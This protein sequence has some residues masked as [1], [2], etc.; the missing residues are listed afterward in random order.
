MSIKLRD[1]LIQEIG[2]FIT[3]REVR[4]IEIRISARLTLYNI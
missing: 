1:V 2:R 4:L 3:T